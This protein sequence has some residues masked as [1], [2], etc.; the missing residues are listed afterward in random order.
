[1]EV[2]VGSPD[3]QLSGDV[4]RLQ[5]G[6]GT[7]LQAFTNIPNWAIDT[8][9]WTP[10][11]S[12]SCTN[13]LD[14]YANP[15]AT[16][17]YRVTIVNE[18]GCDDFAEIRVEID[19]DRKVYIPNAFSPNDDGDNDLF[20]IYASEIGIKQVNHF[21]VYSRWGEMLYQAENF[22]PNDPAYGWG[23]LFR[24]EVMNPGVFV[25][26]AEVEFVDGFKGFYKGDVTLFR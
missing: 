20:M 14:P 1:V 9:I 4:V 24:G 25:Y 8:I 23:G 5:L 10:T 19:K 18:N 17:T 22:Q 26:W 16:T 15:T 11:D 13:C 3:V 2:Q 7:Q 12:L 6:A 21:Q